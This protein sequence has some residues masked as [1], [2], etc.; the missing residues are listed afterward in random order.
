MRCVEDWCCRVRVR[1][2]RLRV[3]WVDDWCGRVRVWCVDDWCYRV[4]VRCVDDWCGSGLL[5]PLN[6]MNTCGSLYSPAVHR[7]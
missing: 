5:H 6:R 7:C 3:R 4:R 1:C 2:C